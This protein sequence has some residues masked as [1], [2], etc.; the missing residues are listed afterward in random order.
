[1][2]LIRLLSCVNSLM[3]QSF[4]V[5]IKSFGTIAADKS[6][7]VEVNYFFMPLEG[8]L[9]FQDFAT[10][11]AWNLLIILLLHLVMAEVSEHAPVAATK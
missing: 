3:N 10:L 11:G 2:Y 6:V 5:A 9:V 1:M 8:R 4:A 7:C